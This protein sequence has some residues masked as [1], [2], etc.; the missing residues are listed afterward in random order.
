M[1]DVLF[2][3]DRQDWATPWDLFRKIESGLGI[4]FDLDVCAHR[5]NHKCRV[6]F[7]ERMDG[8]AQPWA[9]VCW[10]NPPYGREISKWMR[11]AVQ[12]THNGNAE[13]VVCL[14]PAR[15]DTAW[16]HDCVELYAEKPIFLRGRI[17]FEGTASGAPFPSVIVIFNGTQQQAAL[18][19][20]M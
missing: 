8:L 18:P 5:K 11:K 15:T 12:E 17:K 9:G 10:M 16:W 20:A 1:N 19:G 3:S 7:N 4:K 13:R 14:L 6:Y 2:S